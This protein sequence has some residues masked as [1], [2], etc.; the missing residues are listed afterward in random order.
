MFKNVDLPAIVFI[1]VAMVWHDSE[2][3]TH[4]ARS[5][6]IGFTFDALRAGKQPA[7]SAT[8]DSRRMASTIATGS[9]GVIP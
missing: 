1:T 2:R 6:T 7:T 8:V 4:S 9:F 5:A 3:M